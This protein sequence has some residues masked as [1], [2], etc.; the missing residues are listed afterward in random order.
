VKPNEIVQILRST[1]LFAGCKEQALMALA[2]TCRLRQLPKGSM[3][4]FQ[5]DPAEALFLVRSGCIAIFLNSMDGR[6]LVINEARAGDYFG[7][8]S[9][10][11]G[12]PR[13]ASAVARE[14]SELLM[15]PATGFRQLL[16]S[17][18]WL[19]QYLLKMTALR[20]TASTEREGALAF[21]DAAGRVVRTLLQ[22]DLENSDK[23]YITLSQEE[24][25]QRTG[26]SR[27][28]VAKILGRW[29]R[30]GWLLTGR[31]RIMLLNRPALEKVAQESSL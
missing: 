23:G 9:L 19:M 25:A 5:A 17:D 14:N 15:I 12:Q 16:E 11:T 21:L 10:L 31:G 18:P 13:S 27:Q 30:S 20:L 8:L 6:E 7:E 29:R 1:P 3:V 24:L 2:L 22:L 28:T 4:F 26:L